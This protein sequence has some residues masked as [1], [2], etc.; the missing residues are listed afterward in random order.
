MS[1][2]LPEIIHHLVVMMLMILIFFPS[3]VKKKSIIFKLE[4]A[5]LNWSARSNPSICN[6][7]TFLWQELEL[8]LFFQ[9]SKPRQ[10][11]A[12]FFLV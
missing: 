1:M 12:H 11:H 5:E 8:I 3:Q 4:F 6:V 10:R 9:I 2:P 7:S